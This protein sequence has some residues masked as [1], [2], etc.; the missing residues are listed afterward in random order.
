MHGHF[1][2]LVVSQIA[3]KFISLSARGQG[4]RSVSEWWCN[5]RFDKCGMELREAF[6]NYLADFFR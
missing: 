6:K 2:F 1:H 4:P 5:K 3:E